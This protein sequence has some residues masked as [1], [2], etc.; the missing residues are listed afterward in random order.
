MQPETIERIK[1]QV[2]PANIHYESVDLG[3]TKAENRGV[4]QAL[5]GL[6]NQASVQFAG[7]GFS[8]NVSNEYAKILS[9]PSKSFEGPNGKIYREGTAVGLNN[10]I[11]PE[12]GNPRYGC[13]SM[14]TL[15]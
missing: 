9:D 6:I 12:T 13:S 7:L 1:Q 8:N 5:L 10:A 11:N 4:L 15:A 3:I 14:I 2:I